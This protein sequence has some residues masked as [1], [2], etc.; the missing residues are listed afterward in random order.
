MV[1]AK[2]RWQSREFDSGELSGSVKPSTG[3]AARGVSG[4]MTPST[5][6]A[7]EESGALHVGS[8]RTLLGAIKSRAGASSVLPDL[9]VLRSSCRWRVRGDAI[10]RGRSC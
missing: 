6:S 3:A 1:R 8:H 4:S 7:Q 10:V 5:A 2:A 9:V